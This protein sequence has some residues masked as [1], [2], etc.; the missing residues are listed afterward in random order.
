MKQ[1]Y[2]FVKSFRSTIFIVILAAG[3]TALQG[4]S[5]CTNNAVKGTD[6]KQ[7]A[8]DTSLFRP[9]DTSTIPHDQFGDMVRY[10]R[11]LIVNTAYYIG[12]NG[13]VGKYLGN[14]MNCTNCHM[15]AGTRPFGFNFFSTHARY[16]QYRG[17]ENLVLNLG[18]RINNCIERPHNGTPL[19]LDSKEIVAM[20][21]YMKWLSANVPVGQHVKGDEM[22]ELEYPDRMADIQKGAAIYNAECAVCHGKNG[23][24]MWR[25]DSITYLYPPLWGDLA[26]QNGS[27]PSRV[28][29]LARFIK[30]N[31][32][33]KKATW[34]KPYLTDEQAIDVAAFINDG[35]IHPRPQKKDKSVPDYSDNKMK[36]IDYEKGPYVDTFS[37]MQH[38]FGPYKPIIEDHKKRNLPVIF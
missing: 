18:E 37:E 35:R 17:R 27:S 20:E 33:D 21:C 13:T 19:P 32:P 14:K 36:A 9:P 11:E 16:P 25:P 4:I 22:P 23:E 7:N 29:K 8:N 3:I 2:A 1:T 30:A 26:Y 5:G 15:D 6:A 12:P 31:M 38:K 28:L 24:G 34:R 10:G